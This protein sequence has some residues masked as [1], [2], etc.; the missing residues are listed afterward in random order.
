MNV[1][2]TLRIVAALACGAA[3]LSLTAT[4]QEAPP[5]GSPTGDQPPAEAPQS[6][7]PTADKAQPQEQEPGTAR[8]PSA[9]DLIREFQKEQ[10]QAVP[11]QPKGEPDEIVDRA[12]LSGDRRGR[13]L[14]PDGHVLYEQVGRVVKE[15]EEYVF[16]FEADN[17][18][19]EEPPMGLLKNQ[20]LE[21]MIRESRGGLDSVVFIITAEVTLFQGENFLIPRRVLRKRDLG[22]FR[23]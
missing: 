15:G 9:A 13:P 19:Y 22:N 10:P 23:K 4:A 7:L 20:A 3:F 21:R 11:L 12:P 17:S 16:V 5:S 14:L 6:D 8:Q 2:S 1:G 18:E